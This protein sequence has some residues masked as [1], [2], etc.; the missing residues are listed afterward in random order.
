MQTEH[1]SEIFW[2]N[3][4]YYFF[5]GITSEYAMQNRVRP[6]QLGY[7]INDFNESVLFSKSKTYSTAVFYDLFPN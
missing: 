6:M 4:L 2:Q 7:R 1:H 5:S 3:F